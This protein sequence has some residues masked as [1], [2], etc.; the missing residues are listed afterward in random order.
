MSIIDII[1]KFLSSILLMSV[2]IYT[3]YYLLDKPLDIK[4]KKNT[5]TILSLSV[6]S[7]VNYYI[8]N[9]YI[10]I[11]C[12]TIILMLFF[13][14]LFKENF[15]KNILVPV[16]QQIIIMLSEAIFI[17]FL[18]SILGLNLEKLLEGGYLANFF[19][20]VGITTVAFILIHI[21]ITKK[22]YELIIMSLEKIN[23]K[24]MLVLS[25]LIIGIANVLAMI[26][27]FEIDLRWIIIINVVFTLFCFVIVL[28]SFRM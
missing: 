7:I 9:Q 4:N 16:Y 2:A 25:L 5:I 14:Y 13:K 11:F 1:F 12:I 17:L 18:V 22:V 10:R 23:K 28:Y 6:I 19:V 24:F 21:P 20:N 3:W 8:I 15:I 27:Y 26:T